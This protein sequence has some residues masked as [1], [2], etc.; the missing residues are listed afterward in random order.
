MDSY[1][2]ASRTTDL[3]S[4]ECSFDIMNI[5]NGS[6]TSTEL[7]TSSGKCQDGIYK[8]RPIVTLTI[9]QLENIQGNNWRVK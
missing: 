8:M 9:D 5:S 2:V 7:Y 3:K 6:I 4:S 1:W